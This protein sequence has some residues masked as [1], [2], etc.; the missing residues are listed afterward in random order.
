MSKPPVHAAILRTLAYADIFDFALTLGELHRFLIYDKPV[1]QAVAAGTLSQLV[2]NH[3]IISSPGVGEQ[4]TFFALQGRE[5]LFARKQPK[6]HISEKKAKVGE[7]VGKWL[8]RVPGLLA[9]YFTG[10]I[11][12]GNAN[13]FD[14]IDIM[15]ITKPGH[16][17]TS[18]LLLTGILELTG[19]RRKPETSHA[20]RQ[21]TDKICANLYL[22]TDHLLIPPSKQD[23]YTAHE[24]V[25]AKPLVA[26]PLV[27]QHFLYQNRWVKQYLPNTQI[28][29]KPETSFPHS[30]ALLHPTAYRLQRLYMNKRLTNELITPGSAY[31]HPRN[32]SLQVLTKYHLKLAKLG[33]SP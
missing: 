20:S 17:W 28:P 16:L 9:L 33:L 29:K 25:Q 32:T 1:S 31:F 11:A 3:R 14:D 4:P 6:L 21:V 12:I 7:R 8:I 30:P 15:I 19:K 26:P 18:R 22:D 27:H 23:L 13:K 24:V 5:R 2:T 10:T